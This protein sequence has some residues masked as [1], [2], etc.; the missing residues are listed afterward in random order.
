LVNRL[1]IIPGSLGKAIFPRLS[2]IKK[3]SELIKQQRS[4]YILMSVICLPLC[5][6]IFL[7]AKEILVLW[8][9]KDYG[10]DSALILKIVIMGFLVNCFSQIPFANIQALGKARFTA[11]IHAVEIVPYGLLLV[12]AAKNYGLYGVAIS[13]TSRVIVDFVLLLFMSSKCNKAMRTVE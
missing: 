8:M 6:L 11:F 13:W 12:Y 10:G 5:V 7:F 2:R 1:S 9:G 3:Y 4:A